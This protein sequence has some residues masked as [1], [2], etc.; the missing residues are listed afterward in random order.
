MCS[1]VLQKFS[2]G[3]AKWSCGRCESPSG[4]YGQMV[5]ACSG[6]EAL[7]LYVQGGPKNVDHF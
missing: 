4:I 7:V 2:N 3:E 6:L 5:Q 1:N